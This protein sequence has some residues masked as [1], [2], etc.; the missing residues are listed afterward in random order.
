MT[1]VLV[2][3][4]QILNLALTY[5]YALAEVKCTEFL[6]MALYSLERFLDKKSTLHDH[7]IDFGSKVSL[8]LF[9]HTHFEINKTFNDIYR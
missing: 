8:S 7:T 1:S 6:S 4:L 2:C 3:C 5:A 9:F